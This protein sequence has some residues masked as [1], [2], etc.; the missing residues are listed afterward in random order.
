MSDLAGG[1]PARNAGIT[2]EVLSGARGPRRDIVLVNAAMG[3]I[4]AGR[5]QSL[6]EAMKVAAESIDSGAA[7]AK[8]AAMSSG[9]F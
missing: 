4:A 1:D 8:L 9:N 5:A 7:Q 3:L 6:Q 2:R